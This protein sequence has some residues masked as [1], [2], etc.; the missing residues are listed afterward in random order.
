MGHCLLIGDS[1][2]G[3]TVLSKFVAWMQ[4]L[5]I[6]QIKPH[7]RYT[8]DDFNEDLRKVLRRVGVDGEK[9]CFIFDETNALSGGFLEAMN[10]LLASGEV[11]GLFEGENYTALINACRDS[12]ARDG[13]LA[14]SEDE[15][16]RRFISVVQRNLHIVFTMNPHGGHWKNRTRSS[17][18]LFNRCVVDWIGTWSSKALGSV[19]KQLTSIV[20]L[21]NS[22]YLSENLNVLTN[23]IIYQ[24]RDSFAQASHAGLHHAVVAAMVEIHMISLSTAEEIAHSSSSSSRTYISPRDYMDFINTILSTIRRVQE[25]FEDQQLHVNAGISKFQQTQDN[26]GELKL[27]LDKKRLELSEKEYLAN[28]KLQQMVTD[29]KAAEAQ[30]DVVE[31]ISLEV[32]RQECEINRRKDDAQ[33]QLDDAEPALLSSKSAVNAISKKDLD[34]V[35]NLIRPPMNVQKTLECIAVMLGE[36][37]VEWSDVRKMINRS[38][39][40]P[41]ILNFDAGMLTSS[42][43]KI[44]QQDYLDGNDELNYES[45]MRSSRACGPLYRWAESQVMYSIV[46]NR[47]QPLREEV[48]R[49]ITEA[50]KV[51][52]NKQKIEMEVHKLELS[53]EQYKADYATLIRD[54]EALKTEM[55][56]VGMKIKRAENLITSFQKESKRWSNTRDGF[57]LLLQNLVGDSL[58]ISAFLTYSGFFDFRTRASLL[59]R[60]MHVLDCVEVK[61]NRDIDIVASLST[62]SERLKWSLHGLSSDSLS[63]ENGVILKHHVR[64]PLVIDPSG[65]AMDFI[66][67]QYSDQKIQKTSFQDNAFVKTLTSAIRFGTYLMIENV[68]SIDPIIFPVLNRE[69]QRTGGRSLIRVGADEVDYSP[70][71]SLFLCTKNPAS[72][73]TPDICSKVTL[74][75]FTQ[76]P[77]SLEI[78]SLSLILQYLRPDIQDKRV[79]GLRLH[80]EQTIRLRDLENKMLSSISAVAGNILDNDKLVEGMETLTCEGRLLEEQMRSCAE[81]MLDV[82]VELEKYKNI[83]SLCRKLF[84]LLLSMRE[85]N[86]LYEFSAEFLIRTLEKILTLDLPKRLTE[87]EKLEQVRERLLSEITARSARRMIS[88]DKAVFSLLLGRLLYG[89]RHDES[90]S[91]MARHDECFSSMEEIRRHIQLTFG[92]EFPSDGRGIV[93]LN[94]I[95][96]NDISSTVPLLICSAPGFD[97]SSRIQ[98]MADDH[99]NELDAMAMGSQECFHR[100]ESML[101][102]ASKRGSWVLLKNCHLCLEWL[103][104]TLLRKLSSIRNTSH[105]NFRLFLSSEVNQKLPSSLIRVCDIL[106][107]EAPTGLKASLFRVFSCINPSRF[108]YAIRNRLYLLLSWLHAVL[109]ERL[110]FI[111]KGWCEKYEFMESDITYALDIID[112]LFSHASKGRQQLDPTNLPWLALR[113]IL[114]HDIY[115]GRIS[116]DIDR[117]RLNDIINSIF[118]PKA[119]DFNFR[120]GATDDAP[121]LPEGN[122]IEEYRIWIEALPDVTSPSWVGLDV[123]EEE[124]LSKTL[125]HSVLSKAARL[126]SIIL[127]RDN[128]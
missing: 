112:E 78:Q 7:S 38:D 2:T 45:V 102:T 31:K 35:R 29:Q 80:S 118:Q 111:P 13:V 22:A 52:S 43:I 26:V 72:N 15:L 60:W 126:N 77:A 9:I 85:I 58:L 89:A 97:V 68:E 54:V 90:F 49:L 65:Q 114:S 1:G 83:A 69:I 73:L 6:F 124:I 36:K 106:L 99:G 46:H 70:K 95:T 18:A 103:Q 14:V 24:V 16:W 10:A 91:S 51:R 79:G 94:I 109:Q 96:S 110:R 113:T 41:S 75:N 40:I 61:F 82:E 32:E 28:Q 84:V 62:A 63:A 34:E 115:G 66:M 108:K 3:K 92:A 125:A 119:Y 122:T 11:P 56:L 74:V 87:K 71:F 100:A 48:D 33:R 67:S 44:V 121:T 19:G 98:R 30:R 4:G 23:P 12:A 47:V 42:Q 5:S 59:N 117:E 105:P 116:Q 86:L 25:E 104:E 17:P 88:D 128:P 8:L 93:D 76:T 39:F 20:D 120:L 57:Y 21:D 55:E 81:S 127:E 50:G 27:A 101:T 64:Y 53:I 123:T 107:A 37:K